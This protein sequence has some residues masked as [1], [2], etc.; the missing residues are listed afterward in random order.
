MSFANIPHT[1]ERDQEP[2]ATV[3]CRGPETKGVNCMLEVRQLGAAVGAEIHGVDLSLPLDSASIDAIRSAFVA[4]IVLL[5]RGQ[6]LPPAA[7]IAF[8]EHFGAVEPHPLSSRPGL[9]DL[10]QLMVLENRPGKPGARNDFWHSDISHA[11]C[12]PAVSLLHALEVPEGYGDTM[13]CNMYAAFEE[14][15]PGMQDMLLELK[16]LHSGEATSRRNREALTDAQQIGDVPPPVAHPVVRT[17]PESGRKAIYVNPFFTQCFTDMSDEESTPILSFLY[18]QAT[19]PENV[20]RHRWAQGDVL[21][22]DN[23]CT[24][25]YAVK[26]YDEN[27][28]RHMHRTTAAGDQPR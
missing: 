3:H 17:H 7:Q 27:M 28:R 19:R 16:A 1:P 21:M 6:S 18:A 5:F 12:P 10:P 11:E 13:F 15:S 24:M 25:H 20:Y 14:L 22:W 26:D 23:R 2:V 9:P 8:T 4:H